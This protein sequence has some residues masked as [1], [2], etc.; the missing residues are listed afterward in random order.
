[1]RLAFWNEWSPVKTILAVAMMLASAATYGQLPTAATYS[2]LLK[3]VS[4]DGKV[5]YAS[6]C[7]QGTTEHKTAIKSSGGGPASSPETQ[8][9]SL[10]E[11][12][13]EFKKR[14]VE[15]QEARQKEEK[16]LAEADQKRQACDSAQTYLKS[17]QAGNRISR[18]DPR[19]GERIFLED[20][21]RP[22]EVARA[23]SA[24]DQNCK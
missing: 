16:K 13:A 6:Q 23:Q 12:D 24:A 1:M 22:A 7:P 18:T 10:V 8:Q 19:T 5:E 20:A 21:D 3:C 2:Q 15:Q 4:K 17:L 9:K 11:R 14:L